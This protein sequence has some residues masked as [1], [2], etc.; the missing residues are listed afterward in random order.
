MAWKLGRTGACRCV[1]GGAG[2]RGAGDRCP[3]GTTG[4][5]VCPI[6][7]RCGRVEGLVLSPRPR[8]PYGRSQVPPASTRLA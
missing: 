1:T 5:Q 8:S 7:R 2:G 3:E 4:C 6:P